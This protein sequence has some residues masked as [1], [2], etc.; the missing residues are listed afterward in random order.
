MILVLVLVMFTISMCQNGVVIQDNSNYS[1]EAFQSYANEQYALHFSGT[2]DY[3]DNLLL[4][5]LTSEDHYSYHYI[6]WVGDH[7][8]YDIHN[9][10]GNE[11]T[12]L[13]QAMNSCIN[14][15]SYQYSLGS[16]LAQVVDTLT[17]EI[18]ALNL[19]SSFSCGGGNHVI[20]DFAN[21][22][23]LT[24]NESTVTD[25]LDRF[26]QATGI[27]IVLVV[28]DSSAVFGS[29]H[30]VSASAVS[31]FFT[32]GIIVLAVV[33]AVVL[34]VSHKKKTKSKDDRYRDYHDFDDQY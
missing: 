21:Y 3:E 22:T 20:T 30:S 24:I 6:A 26:A 15:S 8:V 27:S 11:Y 29:E 18:T 33:I 14:Q 1:E 7:I 16:N 28:E 34:L 4:V 9:M 23:D 25:A 17:E 32:V 5:M 31:R 13:G 19:T 12:E 10:L 2:S